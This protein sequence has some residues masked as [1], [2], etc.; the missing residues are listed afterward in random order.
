MIVAITP[1]LNWEIILG[2]NLWEENLALKDI[3]F[4]MNPVERDKR[5]QT[6]PPLQNF[7]KCAFAE[8]N[9]ANLID[10]G[11]AVKWI[12]IYYGKHIPPAAVI[13]QIQ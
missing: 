9:H 5:V 7:E 8:S 12:K 11:R 2:N 10:R 4:E 13:D 6:Q 1:H 3:L